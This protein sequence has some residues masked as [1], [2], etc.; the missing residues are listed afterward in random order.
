M[1]I[2]VGVNALF[3]IKCRRTYVLTVFSHVVTLAVF[4]EDLKSYAK[5]KLVAHTA[6]RPLG[7][8]AGKNAS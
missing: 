1:N 7:E 3:W 2:I 4:N 8:N 5:S 6:E